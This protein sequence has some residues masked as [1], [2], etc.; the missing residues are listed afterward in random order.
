[1]IPLHVYFRR[2]V[3]KSF[4]SH[5]VLKYISFVAVKGLYIDASR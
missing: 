4:F 3:K 1:M 2:A 5:P